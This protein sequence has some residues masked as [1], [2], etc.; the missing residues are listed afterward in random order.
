[1]SSSPSSPRSRASTRTPRTRSRA[2]RSDYLARIEA[3]FDA[4]RVELGVADE[5]KE[6]DGVTTE[7]LVK[8]GENEVKTV[9]DLAGCATDDLVGWTERKG[10]ETTRHA[11]FL[12]GIEISREEAEAIVMAARVKAGWIEAPAEVAGED[13]E[14]AKARRPGRKP[15][16]SRAGWCWRGAAGRDGGRPGRPGAAVRRDAPVASLDELIRFVVGPDDEL[17]P[18]L[19]HKLPGRGVWVTASRSAVAEALKKKAFARSLKATVKVS[20]IWRDDIEGLLRRSAR[21]VLQPGQQGGAGGFGVLQGRGRHRR[22]RSDRGGRACRRRGRG[23]GPQAGSGASRG[24]METGPIRS[25]L[26][27]RSIRPNWV[28]HWGGH[29]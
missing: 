20:P 29:M 15:R 18:D 27:P 13:N 17:V 7:M 6:V 24:A 9:E 25:R 3:E 11:G 14:T 22:T 23:R 16:L 21:E 8:L 5:L 28:W 19:K 26:R 1:M 2:A 12:D 4:R 10:G